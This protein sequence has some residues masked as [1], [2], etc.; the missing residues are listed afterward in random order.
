MQTHTNTQPTLSPISADNS[1]Y[2]E[3]AI[4]QHALTVA[5]NDDEL[6]DADLAI[7]DVLHV[8]NARFGDLVNR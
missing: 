2:A 6:R 1:T 3:L 5:L 4:V 8:I 7:L